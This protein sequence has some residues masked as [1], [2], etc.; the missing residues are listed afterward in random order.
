MQDVAIIRVEQ[1][2]P[3]YYE[4]FKSSVAVFKNATEFIWFQ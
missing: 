3:F 2:A 4:G 1:L